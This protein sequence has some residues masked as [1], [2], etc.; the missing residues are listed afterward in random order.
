MDR[1]PSERIRRVLM[2]RL[3]D[4]QWRSVVMSGGQR[5]S[6]AISGNQWHS[7]TIS[8]TLWQ[9]V[10]L[11]GNQRQS[12]A[13]CGNQWHSVA[14][15]GTRWQSVA[16]SIVHLSTLIEQRHQRRDAARLG[17]REAIRRV[18]R[19]KKQGRGGV[20]LAPDAPIP[21]QRH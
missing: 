7:V 18:C 15:G 3:S 4:D 16:I 17:H 1:E 19:Q 2:S 13:L 6:V 11:C 14:L 10:A 21:Q 8:G 9:S 12:V 20:L 5:Q